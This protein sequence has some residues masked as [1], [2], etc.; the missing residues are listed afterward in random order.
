MGDEVDTSFT[1]LGF[2]NNYVTVNYHDNN[3]LS[4]SSIL[5][6]VAGIPLIW[7]VIP[8]MIF[9][10]IVF[11]KP[12]TMKKVIVIALYPMG[13]IISILLGMQILLIL[14]MSSFGQW[15]IGGPVL[16]LFWSVAF[17][18]HNRSYKMPNKRLLKSA[19]NTSVQG[20]GYQQQD[21]EALL[22]DAYKDEEDD[23]LHMHD[24]TAGERLK[25]KVLEILHNI[26]ELFRDM[27]AGFYH[28][29]VFS[30]IMI[31]FI[32]AISFSISLMSCN[33]C[34]AYFPHSVSTSFSRLF[35]KQNKIC[36]M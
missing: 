30:L 32:G 19:P 23:F 17:L 31:L 21:D 20:S 5:L 26:R 35:L 3:I 34:I 10:N 9:N 13:I 14:V 28:R 22:E 12:T 25:T 27:A 24:T 36:G 29:K 16:F 4:V 33:M 18:F 2:V 1:W 8:L 7:L 15:Y 11:V 6:L